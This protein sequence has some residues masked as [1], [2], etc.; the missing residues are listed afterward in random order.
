MPA[1]PDGPAA[2]GTSSV[3]LM[4]IVP[5]ACLLAC[6]REV[7]AA[8]TGPALDLGELADAAGA[9]VGRGHESAGM[10]YFVMN[11]WAFGGRIAVFWFWG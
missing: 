7:M 1:K 9:G 6:L 10:L 8:R 3:L 2:P 5:V 4:D 11:V